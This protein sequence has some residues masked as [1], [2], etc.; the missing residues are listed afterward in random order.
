MYDWLTD[1]LA[2][3]ATVVTANRRLA[4]VLQ[5]EFAERQMGAGIQAWASPRILSWPDWI[6]ILLQEAGSQEELPTRINQHHS[7]LLWDRCLRKELQGE[8]AGT[9]NLVRLARDTWQRLADWCIDIREVARHAQ[10]VDQRTF[11]AA[12]GRYAGLLDHQAWVDDAGSAAL[13]REL[14]DQGRIRVTGQITFAGFD[15]DRPILEQIQTSLTRQGCNVRN[16]AVAEPASPT[17]HAFDTSDAEMRAAGSWAR[18]RLENAPGERIAIVVNHLERDAD[19]LAGLVREGLLPGYRLSP[20][21]PAEAL[22]V[23]YG[24]KLMAY[25][26][27]STGLLWL[28]W[29]VCDLA[30]LDVGHL[31]RSPLLGLAPINGRARLELVLR[32]MPDREWSPAMATAALRG[33]DEAPDAVDWLQRVAAL[34]KARRDLPST[35]SP[36]EWAIRFDEALA[37]AGWPGQGTLNSDDFQLVNRWRDLLNDLARMALVSSR[38]TKETAISQLEGMAAVTVFQPE[39]NIARAQ[40]LGPLEASVL[41]F[42][43]IWLAGMT[44]SEWPP[45]GNPS[46]LVSRRLQQEHG[47]PD[48]LPEDT[49]DYARGLFLRICAAAPVVVCSYPRTADDAEQSPSELLDIVGAE[50]GAPLPDPGWHAANWPGSASLTVVEDRL[51]SVSTTER[52]TGGAST[53]QN[54]LT[55][56][57]SAFIGGRLDVRVLDEQASGLPPLLRGNLVHYALYKLYID[58]P[59]RDELNEW[60]D[61]DERIAN[62]ID[63]AFAR[64]ERNTDAV[65]R[66]LLALERERV[67]GLLREFIAL[68]IARPTFRVAAVEQQLTLIEAGLEIKLRIDRVDRLASG[69]VAIIDYK[70]GAEKK[71]L[72]SKG[73]PREVQLVAYACA[74]DE[75]VAALVLANVDSRVV[76]FHGAGEGFSDEED[77]DE[78]LAAW[79]DRVRG[80]CGDIARGDVRINRHQSVEEARSLNLLTRYTELRNAW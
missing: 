4:R 13:V 11:A 49:V 22:N 51:P 12:A 67:A 38:M 2:G 23:S 78:R 45:H 55:D 74:V 18:A 37:A 19:R 65:L 54:Q 57:I 39:S 68:D 53:I 52:L 42:D 69:R 17:F 41:E 30:A 62:A 10:S 64:H 20:Q 32:G 63:F 59:S 61:L 25:P 27:V 36:A 9:A 71:F 60:Q 72:D 76:G 66:K 31:M 3:N 16:Q 43:A 47:M 8:A 35:A 15:R 48:A 26:A 44:A 50:S 21:L 24:R 40:L 79:S 56:P 5:Q 70:T 80:A 14:L 77:W 46:V 58:K 33:K 75:P 1:A 28:R 73:E 34:T 29:L 6:D 7:A